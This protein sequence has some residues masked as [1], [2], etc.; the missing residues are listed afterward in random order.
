M[1]F[2]QILIF[3]FLFILSFPSLAQDPAHFIIGEKHFAN[4]EIY[5]LFFDDNSDVLYAGTNDGVYAYKQ[6][7]FIKLKDSKEQI[8]S[9][10]FQLKKNK[11]G[12]IFCCN[13]N[14][15]IFKIVDNT[16]KIF[17][18]LPP[19]ET[20]L[21]FNFF[22]VEDH[23]IIT[24]SQSQIS[25]INEKGESHLLLDKNQ[26]NP[27]SDIIT[28]HFFDCQQIPNGDIYIPLASNYSIRYHNGKLDRTI[29]PFSNRQSTKST[30]LSLNKV[31]FVGNTN[32]K[33][34]STNPS[35]HSKVSPRFEERLFQ[36]N[37]HEIAGLG[38]NRGIRILAL[39]NDTLITT[40]SF[41]EKQFI[42]AICTNKNG[43]LFLGSFG[44]GV[45]I[46]PNKKVIQ[47]KYDHLFLG[48]ATS[49][50]NEVF[51]S[52]RGGE[53]FQNKNG[54]T[55]IDK[56]KYNI[57]KIFYLKGNF[58]IEG[59]PYKNT[60]YDT[61]KASIGA[62]KD[63]HQLDT[64]KFVF[65][66]RRALALFNKGDTTE[67]KNLQYAQNVKKSNL[68]FISPPQRYNAV[69]WSPLDSTFFYSNSFGLFASPWSSSRE[70]SILWK[71]NS[72]LGNDLEFYDN[73]LICGTKKMG[74]LFFKDKKS[75]AQISQKDGLKSNN[76]Q[77]IL[78]KDGLLYILTNAGIQVYHLEKKEFL[79]LGVAEGLINDGVTNFTI[80]NDKLWLME[81]HRFYSIDI[82]SFSN[83]QQKNSIANLYLDSILIN[84]QSID[85]LYNNTF[86]YQENE[87]NIF[88]D[89]RNIESK[90]ETKIQYILEGFY[91]DW[92]TLSSSQNNIEFQ[93]LPIGNYTFKIKASYRNQATQPF[94]YSFKITPPI[95]QRWW[96]YL[97][98]T[99][100][101]ILVSTFIFKSILNRQRKELAIKNELNI[102]KLT[103]IRSQM[104]PHFIFNAL[105]SIQ[106]LVLKGDVDNSYSFINKFA[107]LVRKTLEFSEEEFITLAEEIHLIEVYLTLEKLR[108]KDNFNFEIIKPDNLEISIPPMLI[109]PFIENA[110]IHGLL[111][112]KGQKKLIVNFQF[113]EQLT[114][115]VEDN[116]VGRVK[117]KAIKDRQT[118]SHKS[119]SLNAIKRR[120]E[121]LN[122]YYKSDLGYEYQD[123]E[124]SNDEKM[125]TKVL[126]KIPFRHARKN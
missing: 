40:Q 91:D 34:S 65:I 32:G 21:E 11:K 28:T 18:Q 101:G 67:I 74:I 49:P 112:K 31:I 17:H 99:F 46:V 84:G 81:R 100:F 75:A 56:R 60:F 86:T 96:F 2:L 78:A 47:P 76:V 69:T 122:N 48:I 4:L 102:S 113:N 107:S 108:F 121:I 109:Q 53:I 35:F 55:L 89:Y 52:T 73:Q 24:I 106:H 97:L 3:S 36:I 43:T 117:A 37:Q 123:F 68:H 1:N 9:S 33:F 83:I 63:F 77:K 88:F 20:I 71:G 79:G 95:W 39:Q 72:F 111:H 66:A 50:E 70:D 6:N 8:G 23:Q 19:D 115:S 105:N 5:T 90:K 59:I 119:F 30:Y 87:V 94:I 98:L 44:E 38:G 116:G 82:A 10:F 27:F 62:I 13:L 57:D 14:G 26:K 45:K 7:K 61:P 22:F 42:S 92:K 58:R 124:P 12:E 80:S 85:Y 125:T 16:L 114:C 126:V 110:I 120:F 41:F 64:N 103:A 29:K 15:Q 25:R 51:L 118:G 93:S 104:N 54:L